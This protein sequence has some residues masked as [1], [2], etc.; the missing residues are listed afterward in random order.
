MDYIIGFRDGEKDFENNNTSLYDAQLNKDEE[1]IVG[2]NE[3]QDLSKKYIRDYTCAGVNECINEQ[4]INK[5][6]FI[7]VSKEQ[8]TPEYYCN[9]GYVDGCEDSANKWNDFMYHQEV[10]SDPS[11]IEE[12]PD[13]YNEVL[14]YWKHLAYDAFPNK[15]DYY[16]AGYK[17]AIEVN[18]NQ[19]ILNYKDF[20]RL[21]KENYY[22]AKDVLNEKIH[23]EYPLSAYEEF[24]ERNQAYFDA[25]EDFNN[26]NTK[27]FD[28]HENKASIYI[29]TYNIEKEFI[30][31]GYSME[32]ELRGEKDAHED[33]QNKNTNKFDANL[34][35]SEDYVFGYNEAME[36]LKQ[37]KDQ[38]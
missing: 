18:K 38:Q 33:Y 3:A 4:S 26:K 27:K 21:A 1:Y 6:D 9:R 36:Y 22:K 5:V 28:E 37:K 29:R 34:D 32:E 10:H 23:Y 16:I 35:K 8:Q 2:Y 30:E 11:I 20:F 7:D 13:Y 14:D 12:H 24:L 31:D 15:N 17:H 25:S 19:T